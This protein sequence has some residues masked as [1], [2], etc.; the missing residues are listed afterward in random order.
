[1]HDQWTNLELRKEMHGNSI[2]SSKQKNQKKIEK[3]VKFWRQNNKRKKIKSKEL[4]N[5]QAAI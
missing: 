1:M 5:Q 4:E 2:D 3:F